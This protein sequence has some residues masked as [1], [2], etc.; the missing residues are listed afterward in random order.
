MYCSFCSGV[1]SLSCLVCPV[2]LFLL[3]RP[4]CS[5]YA[6]AFPPLM[7]PRLRLTLFVPSPRMF[8]VV[9]RPLPLLVCAVFCSL[10]SFHWCEFPLSLCK[11]VFYGP[12]RCA[13]RLSVPISLHPLL[14]VL[15]AV[16]AAFASSSS[17]FLV[18]RAFR[19]LPATHPP[20][21]GERG[22]SGRSPSP[23]R[24][25]RLSPFAPP[26]DFTFSGSLVR[27]EALAG[28]LPLSS[29]LLSPFCPSSVVQIYTRR[30]SAAP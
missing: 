5:A 25:L 14:L 19:F 18:L 11:I 8:R 30:R 28:L 17:C 22:P 4:L 13:N 21:R 7:S 10:F 27:I 20:P 16:V 23:T 2:W 9:S 6:P 3:P 1:A 15:P 29:I 24:S 26:F 12:A